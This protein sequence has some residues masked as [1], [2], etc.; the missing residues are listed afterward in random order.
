MP[1]EDAAGL[2]MDLVI[3]SYRLDG[4]SQA[5][6]YLEDVHSEP[7]IRLPA[8][9]RSSESRIPRQGTVFPSLPPQEWESAGRHLYALCGAG[10]LYWGSYDYDYDSEQTCPELKITVTSCHEFV[11]KEYKRRYKRK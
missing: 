11:F 10:G 2:R 6:C 4:L 5:L 9:T 1:E 7:K 3:L 8:P